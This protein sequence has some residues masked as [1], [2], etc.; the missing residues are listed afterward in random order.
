[1][2]TGSKVATA[3][4]HTIKKVSLELGGKSPFIIFDDADVDQAVEWIMM[5]IFFNQVYSSSLDLFSKSIA[6]IV[7]RLYLIITILYL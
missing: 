2:A 6:L 5:G 1:M 4:G 3:A 7:H